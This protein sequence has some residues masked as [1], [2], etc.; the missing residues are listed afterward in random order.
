M[1]GGTIQ[2][3]YIGLTI[4]FFLAKLIVIY[5]V[6]FYVLESFDGMGI[7]FRPHGE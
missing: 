3:P 4:G 1:L 7:I 5:F 6:N 2:L